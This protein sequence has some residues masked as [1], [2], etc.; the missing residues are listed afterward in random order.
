MI[1]SIETEGLTDFRNVQRRNHRQNTNPKTTNKSS[2]GQ[3]RVLVSSS[4]KHRKHR[5]NGKDSK[6]NKNSTAARKIIRDPSLIQRT[7]QSIY[8]NHSS[9]E[10]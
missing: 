4:L 1:K 9:Q 6:R 8:F 5:T 10:C 7:D 2:N 3:Y